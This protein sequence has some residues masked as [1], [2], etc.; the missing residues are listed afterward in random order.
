MCYLGRRSL[1]AE[2]VVR[3]ARHSAPVRLDPSARRRMSAAREVVE[4][5]L[6]EGGP[7]T[8]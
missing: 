3:V 5:Y 4:R 6:A 8:G 7:R 2:D 1:T